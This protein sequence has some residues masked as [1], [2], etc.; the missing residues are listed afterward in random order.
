LDENR[1]E[2]SELPIGRWTQNY[3]DFLDEAITGENPNSTRKKKA[4]AKGKAASKKKKRRGRKNIQKKKVPFLKDFR[5]YHTDHS[6]KFEIEFL[7]GKL[8]EM[9]KTPETFEKKK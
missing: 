3:K 7:E 8:T 4:P 1:I 9:L 6:V 5:E 2:V